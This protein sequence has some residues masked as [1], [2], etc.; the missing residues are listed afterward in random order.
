MLDDADRRILKVLQSAGR[1]SNVELAERVGL[2]PSP[3]LARVKALEQRGVIKHY[4]ALVDPDSVGLGISVFIQI[5]LERQIE[6]SLDTFE[7]RMAALDEVMECYLMTGDSDY[8]I[9]VVVADLRALERFIVRDVSTIPGVANIRSSM[10]LKQVKYN[11]ALP[12]AGA[13]SP[14]RGRKRATA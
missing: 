2:S 14:Q 6:K 5:T 8:L 4:A 10:A 12:L 13:A 11:T 3:C 1:I 7:K 9:R